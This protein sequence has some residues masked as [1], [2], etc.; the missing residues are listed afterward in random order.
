MFSHRSDLYEIVSG[1]F[2]DAGFEK[3]TTFLYEKA[4]KQYC[5]YL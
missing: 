3:S 2:P 5:Q 4:L 1:V